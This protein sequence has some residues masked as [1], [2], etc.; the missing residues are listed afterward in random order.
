MTGE[1]L[2][3][4]LTQANSWKRMLNER[5]QSFSDWD[6]RYQI[7]N[8]VSQSAL[9]KARQQLRTDNFHIANV[10]SSH[11]MIINAHD[12]L[13]Q[14]LAESE[15]EI[16]A[17]HDNAP[18]EVSNAIKQARSHIHDLV[19]QYNKH[20]RSIDTSRAL[21]QSQRTALLAP[22]SFSVLKRQ[23]DDAHDAFDRS[24]TNVFIG[25]IVDGFFEDVDNNMRHL[26]R[27][28]ERVNSVL[29]SIYERSGSDKRNSESLKSKLLN[30]TKQ[31]GQL[32]LVRKR[33]SEFHFS[34]AILF[35]RKKVLINRFIGSLVF[36]VRNI[37]LELNQYI[38][39]NIKEALSSLVQNGQQQ[40][41]MIDHH[42]QRLAQLEKEGQG[43]NARVSELH[44]DMVHVQAALRAL[45]PLYKDV[46]NA[47]QASD[48]KAN[49]AEVVQGQVVSL[50]DV[51]QAVAGN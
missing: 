6:D 51:R 14:R 46:L 3:P 10:G 30:A 22:I 19:E 31:R 27:E 49:L 11:A 35:T 4:H 43:S 23:V 15:Q 1:T 39:E 44:V 41:Q 24:K 33:A 17:I 18:K 28:I 16:A 36:E 38:D 8:S 5:L 12:G 21:L 9:Y 40:K 34:F 37:Y 45:E 25:Q 48:T 32:N 47:Q 50:S 29:M 2:P 7:L 13:L 20:V 42:K 26:E